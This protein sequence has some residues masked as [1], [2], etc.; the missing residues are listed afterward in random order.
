MSWSLMGSLREQFRLPTNQ[1]AAVRV[2]IAHQIYF[3]GGTFLCQRP[4]MG[5]KAT[6][7]GDRHISA[8]HLKS[9]VCTKGSVENLMTNC[10]PADPPLRTLP[11]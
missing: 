5:Q 7:Q 3:K 4:K 11:F 10:R 9:P 8:L 1:R 6:S 2:S